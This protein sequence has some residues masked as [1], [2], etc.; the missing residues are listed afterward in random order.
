VAYQADQAQFPW[1]LWPRTGDEGAAG[2][3]VPDR[4]LFDGDALF[5]LPPD[6]LVPAGVRHTVSVGITVEATPDMLLPS[7]VVEHFVDQ[8]SVHWIMNACICRDASSCRD[9]PIDLEAFVPDH[10]TADGAGSEAERHAAIAGDWRPAL[11]QVALVA[12]DGVDQR[13]Q[14]PG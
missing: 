4:W 3:H 12:E 11:R 14:A 13:R 6:R 1:P 7:R 5:Y 2:G 8:A 10:A 9:Y